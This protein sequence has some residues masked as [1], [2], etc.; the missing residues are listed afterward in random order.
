MDFGSPIQQ[1]LTYDVSGKTVLQGASHSQTTGQHSVPHMSG[2][3]NTS[4]TAMSSSIPSSVSNSG[5]SSSVSNSGGSIPSSVSNSGGS[6]QIPS[7]ND[8]GLAGTGSIGHSNDSTVPHLTSYVAPM[9]FG[10]PLVEIEK[11]DGDFAQYREF[12]IKIKSVLAMGGYSDDM[13]VIFLKSHLRGEPADCVASIMPDD[14]GAYNK[15]WEVLEEDFGTPALGFDHHLNLLLSISTWSPCNTDDDLKGLYRHISIN[16]DAIKHYGADAAR[17]AEAAK[18]FILP[19]LKGHAAH[20]ITKLHESGGSYNIPSILSIL[21]GIVGH[22]KFLET[23]K[24][25]RYD[26]RKASQPRRVNVIQSEQSSEVAKD[27]AE[28]TAT[29][30]NTVNSSITDRDQSRRRSDR[31]I[32]WDDEK[33]SRRYESPSPDRSRYRYQT[34]PRKPSPVRFSCP[35]CETNDHSLDDCKLYDNRDS[36]WQHIQRKRWCSNC[37]RTGHR[38]R[39]CFKEQSC[40]LACDRLDKHVSVLCDKHYKD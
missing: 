30:C 6:R 21:K 34:P 23:S 3:G 33:Q 22:S 29:L 36:Y 31:K 10:L 17:E 14:P 5:G 16:Y 12:K 20:K 9:P 8:S 13:K 26:K 28:E 40:R 11:F 24:S 25:L 15:I 32:T 19:L 37:L 7:N 18:I 35:F 2:S 38:W 4:H 1:N 27:V 39:D